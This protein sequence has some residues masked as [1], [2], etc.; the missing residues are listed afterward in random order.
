MIPENDYK[1]NKR[2][3][4]VVWKWNFKWSCF[5]FQYVLYV[6]CTKWK[7]CISVYK[8]WLNMQFFCLYLKS[9]TLHALLVKSY[10]ISFC[11]KK[12]VMQLYVNPHATA[13]ALRH[14][15]FLNFTLLSF[16]Y[17]YDL[18]TQT[19]PSQIPDKRHLFLISQL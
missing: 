10:C 11:A 7:F 12:H 9:C 5:P 13:A 1:P 19:K 14:F 2:T 6:L 8:H 4:T 16:Y 15:N 3:K 17:V 18:Y